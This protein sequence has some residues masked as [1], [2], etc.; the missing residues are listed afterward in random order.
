[1]A[2]L[3]N[4]TCLSNRFLLYL[5]LHHIC[6]G[7]NNCSWLQVVKVIHVLMGVKSAPPDI[8]SGHVTAHMHPT[9]TQPWASHLTINYHS[10]ELHKCW[11]VGA[12]NV[13]IK[14]INT[15]SF[16]V[17]EQ[18]ETLLDV[19]RSLKSYGQ[20]L[21][22]QHISNEAWEKSWAARYCKELS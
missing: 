14:D 2:P 8:N 12:K 11:T 21:L 22:A 7:I 1:M 16:S 13:F 10:Y 5:I 4:D 9:C 15:V 3:V 18:R 19:M 17:A 20:N 6:L